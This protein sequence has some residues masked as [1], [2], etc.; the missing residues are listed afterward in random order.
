L[1]PAVIAAQRVHVIH[2]GG[3][4]L[5]YNPNAIFAQPGDLVSFN[6]LQK[7][8]TVVESSFNNPCVPLHDGIFAGFHSGSFTVEIKDTKPHWLYC[9]Q[10][11]HCQAG[12]VAVINPPADPSKTQCTFAQ[13]A[14]KA[15][16]N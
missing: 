5:V 12:M 4:D 2:V 10:A 1:L 6:F 16:A 8:H 11:K 14:A 9:A 3:A 15:P 7:N 13:L